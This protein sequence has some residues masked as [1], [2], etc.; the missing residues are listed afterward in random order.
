MIEY[1]L[2]WG[3]IFIGSFDVG[4]FIVEKV[5]KNL[6]KIVMELGLNDVYIVLDDVDIKNVVE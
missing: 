4:C 2:I 5:G 6:K 3:V 1:E